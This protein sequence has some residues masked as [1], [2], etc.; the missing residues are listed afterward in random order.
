MGLL[1][2]HGCWSGPYSMFHRFRLVLCRV[3][4][5]KNLEWFPGFQAAVVVDGSPVS[6]SFDDH[7]DDPL[8]ILL[9]H[10]DCDGVIEHRHCKPLADR[11]AEIEAIL[12][13]RAMYDDVK[14]ALARFRAGLL[15]AH[16]RGE[17]VE[18]Q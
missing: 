9:S 10:S 3:A 15:L 13:E 12:P 17:D 7:R 18:F 16:E 2:T 8:A 1:T 6:H 5:K 11:L 14:P 4:W